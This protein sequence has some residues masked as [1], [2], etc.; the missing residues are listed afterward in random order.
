[1]C[2]FLAFEIDQSL[3]TSLRISASLTPA[4]AKSFLDDLQADSLIRVL[5]TITGLDHL[6][7]LR[8]LIGDLGLLQALRR[9]ITWFG[10]GR[11]LLRHFVGGERM[12][13]LNPAAFIN[14]SAQI[15]TIVVGVKHEKA[16]VP[17]SV[18]VRPPPKEVDVHII[19]TAIAVVRDVERL[20]NVADQMDHEAKGP[21]LIQLINTRIFQDLAEIV[22]LL[23]HAGFSRIAELVGVSILVDRHVDEVPGRVGGSLMFIWPGGRIGDV[24][25]VLEQ[26]M[27]RDPRPSWTD[28]S[29][30][31]WR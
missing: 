18:K 2:P 22:N 3:N 23:D 12:E 30:R 7:S 4:C 19:P 29:P 6:T 26:I 10:D 20:M 14:L 31:I 1:M 15:I 24:F 28:G 9:P 8:I 11:P 27:N 21:P 16:F 17:N 25:T 5:Q 13:S